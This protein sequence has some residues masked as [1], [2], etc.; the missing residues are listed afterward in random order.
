[1][2]SEA[3]RGR[4]AVA[5]PPAAERRR[6]GSLEGGFGGGEEVRRGGD[7]LGVRCRGEEVGEVAEGGGGG[8]AAAHG[9]RRWTL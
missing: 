7:G 5:G 1:M 3:C 4:G 6:S 9:G 2:A 8:L